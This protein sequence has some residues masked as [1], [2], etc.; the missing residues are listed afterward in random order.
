MWSVTP[1][2]VKVDVH[3][4]SDVHGFV[5]AVP[6]LYSIYWDCVAP[7]SACVQGLRAAEHPLCCVT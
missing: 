2:L 4:R 3:W 6:L 1:D 7:Q 5:F